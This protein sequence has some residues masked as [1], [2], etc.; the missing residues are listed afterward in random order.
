MHDDPTA[1]DAASKGHERL[2]STVK[3]ASR[4]GETAEC[5]EAEGKA[6]RRQTTPSNAKRSQESKKARNVDRD[7]SKTSKQASLPRKG[8]GLIV[9]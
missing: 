9:R 6:K 4:L 1:S 2:A 5:Y 8:G 7:G 3:I